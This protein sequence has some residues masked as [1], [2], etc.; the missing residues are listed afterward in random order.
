MHPVQLFAIVAVLCGIGFL[1]ASVLTGLRGN[2]YV[3]VAFQGKWLLLIRFMLF[4]LVGYLFY[5]L[6]LLF[7]LR[8]P[9]EPLTGGI[10]FAG[11]L[12]VFLVINLSLRT[13]RQMREG[14]E[15]VSRAASQLSRQ[16][17]ELE[18]EVEA[19]RQAQ[20]Q[21]KSRL[22]HLATLHAID[23]IITSSLDLRVTLSVFL[24][25]VAPRLE[26]DALSIL[27]FNPYTQI[28]EYGAGGG[29]RTRGLE[30]TRERLG[31]GSAGEAAR[32]RRMTFI[33][34]LAQ[35]PG[36]FSR[37][38]LVEGEGFVSY[39]AVPLVAKGQ[40]KG[41]LEIFHRE[42]LDPDPEWFEFLQA[43]AVQA[44]IAI[45]NATLFRDLQRSN[46]DL[47]LA[48][49]TTIEGW[50]RA[51]ELRDKDTEGHTRRVTEMTTE[52]ARRFGMGDEQLAHV[53]RGALLHDIGKMGVPDAILL[54]P[55]ELTPE[56]WEVMRKHPVYAFEM[57][58]P[59]A[60]LRPALDIPYCHHEKW[61]GTGYPR[62]LKGEQIPLAA[63]IFAVADMWD[64]L[65]SE[66][67][68][69]APWPRQKVCDHIRSLAG[70]H[71]DPKVVER[72]MEMEWCREESGS[73][74]HRLRET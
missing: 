64:A 73:C 1:T 33:A 32:E 3:P 10:F 13:I 17:L 9:V 37:A 23:T 57:L 59:I 70:S 4:F 20:E 60:Y 26:V 11:S 71:F 7:E 35:E 28:L 34:D 58:S 67:M 29:F 27:L 56:E 22:Q 30:K 45:D 15:E 66:R 41:V 54:K 14:E 5:L 74:N 48:Y 24:E 25:E 12:F 16:N 69:H 65:C 47:V 36:G 46:A 68:Y 31:E 21:A 43:L 8:I 19:R 53:A 62:G 72:W 18:Q 61:N 44:A 42:R 50:S 52:L 6:V 38:A 51:L 55:G 40:I 63:R 49:D 2:R 39:S